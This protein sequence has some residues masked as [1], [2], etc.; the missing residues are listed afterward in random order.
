MRE[1]DDEKIP[2]SSEAFIRSL[3]QSLSM[4]DFLSEIEKSLNNNDSHVMMVVTLTAPNSEYG[5]HS[6]GPSLDL[7]LWHLREPSTP[8][9]ALYTAT[10][11]LGDAIDALNGLNPLPALPSD[12]DED[13]C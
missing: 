2:D 12:E 1:H 8:V 10:A 3:T 9:I 11:L 4:T 13:D 6:G 5:D 7:R